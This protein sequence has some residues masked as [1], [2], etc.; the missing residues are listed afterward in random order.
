MCK[1]KG[2]RT[3]KVHDSYVSNEIEEMHNKKFRRLKKKKKTGTSLGI[4]WL[5]VCRV[6][7]FDPYSGN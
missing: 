5:R 7:K 2:I 4:Q 6:G 1:D 3:R